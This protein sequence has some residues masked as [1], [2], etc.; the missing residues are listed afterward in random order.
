MTRARLVAC[1]VIIV[2]LAAC[3]STPTSSSS[4]PATNLQ[5]KGMTITGVPVIRVVDGD[6]L[7]VNVDGEDVTIRLIGIDTPETVKTDSPIECFGPEASDFAK[8]VLDGQQ[9]TLEFDE[10]QGRTDKYGRT[11]A[12][13]WV[14]L[15]D[16]DRALMNLAAVEGGYA[17]EKQYGPTPFAWQA[18]FRRA[19]EGARAADLGLWG[20]CGS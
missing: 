15:A 12:Y 7:H 14:E 6:T 8:S 19:E 20:A 3:G 16:G 4:L 2:L 17:E 18:E 10:S 9:V 11:L 13:V 5:P 1:A